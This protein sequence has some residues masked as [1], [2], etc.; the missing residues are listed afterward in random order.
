MTVREYNIVFEF[1][2]FP[3]YLHLVC[4]GL[5]ALPVCVNGRLGSVIVAFPGHILYYFF[6]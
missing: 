4:L 2:A 6:K 5:F 1:V 3:V